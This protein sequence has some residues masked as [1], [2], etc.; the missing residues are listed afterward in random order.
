M[1]L[2]RA[3]A[4]RGTASSGLEEGPSTRTYDRA[5]C[6]SVKYEG[7]GIFHCNDT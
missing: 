5:E 3:A 2:A 1:T 4:C 6:G 7:D